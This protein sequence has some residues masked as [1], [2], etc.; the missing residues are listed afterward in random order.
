MQTRIRFY[1]DALNVFHKSVKEVVAAVNKDQKHLV[2]ALRVLAEAQNIGD[3]EAV[4]TSANVVKALQDEY[5][6]NKQQLEDMMRL[7][8]VEGESAAI[9]KLRGKVAAKLK[10]IDALIK[11]IRSYK[12]AD[13]PVL[14]DYTV[15]TPAVVAPQKPTQEINKPVDKP[16]D[17]PT[18]ADY[19]CDMGDLVQRRRK[20]QA[21]AHVKVRHT[22]KYYKMS[23]A[24]YKLRTHL[25]GSFNAKKQLDYARELWLIVRKQYLTLLNKLI[26]DASAKLAKTRV[27]QT[28]SGSSTDAQV[29]ICVNKL[30]SLVDKLQRVNLADYNCEFYK[31]CATKKP[32]N[33]T[34]K[35]KGG[36][37]GKGKKG[38]KI[39]VKP[40]EEFNEYAWSHKPRLPNVMPPNFDRC[41]IG[42]YYRSQCVD[43]ETTKPCHMY[44]SKKACDYVGGIWR[45][46]EFCR[47]GMPISLCLGVCYNPVAPKDFS[48]SWSHKCGVK[49][50]RQF[51]FH[52]DCMDGNYNAKLK[53]VLFDKVTCLNIGGNEWSQLDTI[54]QPRT[55]T[56][57]RSNSCLG[58]CEGFS[59]KCMK[60]VAPTV[61]PGAPTAQDLS[62][63]DQFDSYFN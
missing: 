50:D 21:E 2:E 5:L 11:Q 9:E 61:D 12:P 63:D 42:R 57:E 41:L 3:A 60:E 24:A 51:I 40:V 29:S 15:S 56:P 26:A 23:K 44:Y 31:A 22:W 33:G 53:R 17:K 14:Q 39:P 10:G 34:K 45:R 16:V 19:K 59:Y 30:D 27:M 37:G 38:K 28:N 18:P 1:Q 13:L 55:C 20:W 49:I 6:T 58:I 35:G 43:N 62:S 4:L 52:R 47:R 48:K 54:L 25:Q 7:R 36:K 8:K 46:N 32:D